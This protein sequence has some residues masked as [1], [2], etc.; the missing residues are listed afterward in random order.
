M[1]STLAILALLSLFNPSLGAEPSYRDA[2]LQ[3]A[4]WIRATAIQTDQGRLWPADPQDPKSVNNTLY[5]GTPGVILFFLEAHRSTG[6]PSF[7]RDAETG[8]DHLLT[9]LANEKE[10]GLY[11][12][13]AG[14][15][16]VLTETFKATGE[17]KYRSG[18]LRCTQ[19]LRER[20]VKAG[21][22]V[23][24]NETT[25]IIAGG[26]GIGLFLLYA[27]RELNEPALRELAIQDGH[28]L[29]DLGLSEQSGLKWRMNPS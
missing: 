23:E 24:W 10:S 4:Q 16:Y 28:R 25:D 2:A 3:A 6:D 26:A 29:I 14:I 12:G 15:G 7:L 13:V 20:A 8:A 11:V 21:K 17:L 27:A 5:S 19:L 22:G 9:I 1:R 18:A